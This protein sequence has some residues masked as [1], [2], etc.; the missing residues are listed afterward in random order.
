MEGREKTGTTAWQR[1]SPRSDVPVDLAPKS[2]LA[3]SAIG[4]RRSGNPLDPDFESFARPQTS[5]ALLLH[6]PPTSTVIPTTFTTAVPCPAFIH[7]CLPCP[8]FSLLYLP[9]PRPYLHLPSLP[10]PVPL[11]PPFLPDNRPFPT[12][13]VFTDRP[14]GLRPCFL[15]PDEVSLIR[16][17]GTIMASSSPPLA[18]VP[19]A[20]KRAKSPPMAFEPTPNDA[21]APIISPPL[22]Y[23]PT[24]PFLS[25]TGRI[26][27]PNGSLFGDSPD[28][29]A[30]VHKQTIA[31]SQLHSAFA[32]E[33]EAW[34]C[35]RE[36]LYQR[37]SSLEKLLITNS[38]H[39]PAKSPTMSPSNGGSITSPPTSRLS[40]VN[41][42]LPSI[43]E[44]ENIEPLSRRRQGAPTTIQIPLIDT[45]AGSQKE[46]TNSVV[47][48]AD[49]NMTVEEIPC[50]SPGSLRALSPIPDE[51]KAHAGHTPIK[52]PARPSTPP[53]KNMTLADIDDTPTKHNTHIN[54]FLVRSNDEEE[55][56]A[57]TGPLSMP[58]L[59]NQPGEHN[60]TEEMLCKRLEKIAQSPGTEESRPLIF[61][62]PS[63]GL[64]SPR[65]GWL[66]GSPK[67]V[68]SESNGT[69]PPPPAGTQEVPTQPA[70]STIS[71]QSDVLSN[72][73][74]QVTS[75]EIDVDEA[76]QRNFDQGGIKL[77][78]KASANFGAPFGSLGGFGAIRRSS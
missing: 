62:T 8:A 74:S 45:V 73:L 35:E 57:L 36:N 28:L 72:P 69:V 63:P 12:P 32:A 46:R 70:T 4:C 51:Y 48:F 23:N 64:V 65:N 47:S 43:A 71:P 49:E 24:D 44:D 40:S 20:P 18:D 55:D 10:V 42:R 1:H 6:P 16:A 78:K 7:L 58:E 14:A 41:H 39:S 59:P 38:G 11:H 52:A 27:S 9:C 30:I 53:P 33:R 76:V 31:M 34:S 60:F 61:A 22:G 13:A 67:S 77:K 56:P 26:M 50:L 2:Q 15:Q 3:P 19:Q 25:P 75:N 21:L 29:Q 68:L 37:I 66:E 17:T 54:T 5:W